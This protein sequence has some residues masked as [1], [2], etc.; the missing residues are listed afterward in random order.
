MRWTIS[1]PRQ[2]RPSVLSLYCEHLLENVK[3]EGKLTEIDAAVNSEIAGSC[4]ATICGQ[5]EGQLGRVRVR[6]TR[7]AL[8]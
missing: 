1:W 5:L 4:L 3:V 8:S 7:L 6:G 2:G